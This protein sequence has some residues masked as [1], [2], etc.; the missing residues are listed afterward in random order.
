MNRIDRLFGLVT[1]LQAQ[2]Y[3]PAERL[4]AHFG[5]SLRTVY[6]DLRALGEQG[7]PVS[8]EAGRGYCLVPGLLPAAG[9]LHEPRKPAP[10][11]CSKP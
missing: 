2:R 10:C 9:Q 11:C 1:L 8:F 4:A 5:I 3:V 7:M 6:R